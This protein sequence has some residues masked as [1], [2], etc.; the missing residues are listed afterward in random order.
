MKKTTGVNS[1]KFGTTSA[2]DMSDDV[3]VDSEQSMIPHLESLLVRF[4]T[5]ASL[6]MLM[7]TLPPQSIRV[8]SS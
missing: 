7:Q 1:A 2:N 6:Q 4:L 8:I 5:F 3:T